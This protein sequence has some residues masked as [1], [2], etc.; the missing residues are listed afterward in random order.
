MVIGNL[1]LEGIAIL[2]AE[3]DPVLIIDP[4]AV[5]PSPV[6]LQQFKAIRRWRS[7]IPQLVRAIELNQLSKRYAGNPLE[8]FNTTPIENRLGVLIPKRTYQTTIVLRYA[9]YG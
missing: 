5:L 8:P 2:P 1:N 4:D 9:S 7:K 3:T 6:S